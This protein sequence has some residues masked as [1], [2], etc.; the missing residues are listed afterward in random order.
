VDEHDGWLDIPEDAPD[1]SIAPE[2]VE[3]PD[4]PKMIKRPDLGNS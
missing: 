2:P 3:L 1:D 4:H